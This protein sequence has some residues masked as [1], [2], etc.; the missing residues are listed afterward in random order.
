MPRESSAIASE[1]ASR[2]R[3]LD[4]YLK[5][6]EGLH[7]RGLLTVKDVERAYTG[8][9]LEFY[10][11]L[12]RAI[13]KLFLGLLAR[14]LA[15]SDRTVRPRVSVLST[16]VATDIIFSGRSYADWLPYDRYTLPRA[17]AYFSGGRPFERLDSLEQ[18]ALKN[19]SV[20]RNAL[21]H[22]STAA[23]TNFYKTF[24]ENR[25]LPQRQRRPAAYL[26]GSHT[27]GQTRMSFHLAAAVSVLRKLAD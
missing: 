12:E 26:R 8:G 5:R 9:F 10:A 11:H 16:S 21:A 20:I 23:L 2:A 14:K 22:Q 1:V 4:L 24:V 19:N 27:I 15:S 6:V 3:G 25:N 17:K 18:R 7:S 13:E